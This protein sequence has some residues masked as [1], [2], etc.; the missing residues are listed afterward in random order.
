ERIHNGEIGDVTLL[1]GFRLHP[2]YRISPRHE[3]ASMGELE[4]QI[5]GF[6]YFDWVGASVFIDYCIHNFDTACWAKGMWPE[7]A[8]GF[9]GRSTP[10]VNGTGF[11]TYYT[12]FTFPDG[13]VLASHG[14]YC[15]NCFDRYSDYVH[16]T[17]GSAVLMD[18]LAGAKT[19]TYKNQKMTPENL[20]WQFGE[21]EPNPYQVEHDLFFDAIRNNKPYNE[22]HRAVEAQ[23]AAM[24]SRAAINTGQLVTWDQIVNSTVELLPGGIDNISW[25]TVPEFLPDKDGHYPYA[26]PGVNVRI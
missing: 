13:S 15:D 5:R 22:G 20:T 6:H 12:E 1:R 23:Y 18:G 11:D 3:K 7:S 17:K 2:P 26:I 16:G 14:H 9:G 25:E 24:L 4:Y 10:E 21:A 8:L 19:R